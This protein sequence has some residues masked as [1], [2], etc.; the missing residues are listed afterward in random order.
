MVG[1]E[2]EGVL[3]LGCRLVERLVAEV[4]EEREDADEYLIV[5][6][7]GDTH[8]GDQRED[9]EHHEQLR[10]HAARGPHRPQRPPHSHFCMKLQ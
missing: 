9:K 4:N 8:R 5:H 6:E 2:A 1:A 10:Q 7:G 3:E